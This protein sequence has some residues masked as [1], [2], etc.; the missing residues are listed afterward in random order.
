MRRR[1]AVT[2]VF[3]IAALLG[4]L[5]VPPSH[6]GSRPDAA[7]PRVS[8]ERW[9][10]LITGDR[11]LVRRTGDRTDVT[12]TPAQRPGP[13]RFVELTRRGDRYVVPADAAPKLQAGILDWELFNVS[14]LVRQGYDDQR[15]A[16]LPLLVKYTGTRVATPEGTT[17]RR[18]LPK[19]RMAA[20]D[21]KKSTAATFWR[22]LPTG[23]T[24]RSAGI[25]K[26]WLNAKVRASLD[27]SVARIGAPAAWARDLTGAG[28]TVAVLDTGIDTGHPDFA[29]R[30]GPS[31]DFSGKGNVEDGN[32]HGTHVAS[33]VAGSGAASDGRYKGVAPGATIAV[34]K[35]L[36][37]SG[38]STADTVIAGMHWAATEAEAKVVN[39]SLGSGPT[40]GADPVS[41]VLDTLSREYGTLFVVAAGNEGM[42]EWVSSPAAADEALAVGSVSKNG[43]LSEFSNRGP[44]YVNGAVKPDI[45]A[46]GEGIVAARPSGVPPRGEPVGDAYQRLDGTSMATPHVAGAAALLSQQHPDWNGDA[47]KSALMSTGTE[48]PGAGPYAVGTGRVD[49]NRAT[50]QAVTATG[51]VSTYLRWPNQGAREEKQVTWRN[52]GAADVTLALNANLSDLGGLV[53]LSADS[54]TVPAGGTASVRLTITTRDRAHGTYGG[55]LTARSADGGTV[56]RTALSVRQE[57]ELYD[58]TVKLVDRDGALV[59]NEDRG[60]LV[61]F[62]LDDEDF[63]HWGGPGTVRLPPGRYA[64][65]SVIETPRIGQEPSYTFISHPELTVGK[66]TTVTLDARD[67]K[68]T[69]ITPPNPAARGGNYNV[70]QN[71]RIT[72]CDCVFGVTNAVEPR[73]EVAYAATVPGISSPSFVMGQ[74]RRAVEP[75]VELFTRGRARFEVAAGWLRGSPEPAEQA[76]LKAVYGGAGTP[77]DLAKVDAKG[78]LVLIEVPGETTYEEVYQRTEGIKKAGARMAMVNVAPERAFAL[79]DVPEEEPGPA[80]PTLRGFGVTGA[81]FAALVKAGATRVSYTSRPLSAS[82]YE[83]AYAVQGQVTTAQVHRP[84]TRD[85]VAVRTAYHDNVADSRR[86]FAATTTIHGAPLGG[87]WTEVT[88][89]PQERIE[90]FTPGTWELQS[91]GYWG[92]RDSMDE[93]VRLEAGR[94]YRIVWNKA[95]SGPA[96]PDGSWAVRRDGALD[97]TLPMY[98]DGAGRP[99]VPF[100]WDTDTGSIKLYRDGNLVGEEPVPHH[101][102]FAVPPEQT[103][104][105]LEATT[106]RSVD[107]WPLSTSVSAAWTF[108]SSAAGE[109]AALPLLTVRF[110]PAVDLRNRAPGGRAYG[111]PATVSGTGARVT[112]LAVDVSYDDGRTWTPAAVTRSGGRWA[113]AVTH[114]ASGYASLR[115]RA[116]DADGN[117]VVQTILRAYA[118]VTAEAF[119]RGTMR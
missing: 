116:T 22:A 5:T 42:D 30:L 81:R 43:V 61:I 67:G 59:S 51:G 105:R 88:K 25:E 104:Y 108:R 16:S 90:Y 7:A 44:R 26:V 6:A 24:L 28:V 21:E 19:V 2:A 39:M 4:A 45:A 57:P 99:R 47:L 17:V 78:K 74:S 87:G 65:H 38:E 98:S 117:A 49:A 33:T 66:D 68:P 10:T 119:E 53:S 79:L 113:V 114:P 14:G 36:D 109:G 85:L 8:Q 29:G 69:S 107:W 112:S 73:F 70:T 58:L 41:D 35:V 20:I 11:V 1:T 110:D 71:S 96:F 82:R 15:T 72:S 64:I 83:M 102:R 95:V 75:R 12:V 56:T 13:T 31:K 100:D 94:E 76:D 115:A 86:Y 91:N 62:N 89:A 48:V 97:V 23:N 93:T 50:G 32:G 3:G 77:E 9:V 18:A 55:M 103:T 106:S 63:D 80:L 92:P 101:A 46:P 118:L 111:F 40:D 34:G 37:D 54:V 84:R 60:S 27:E 52:T